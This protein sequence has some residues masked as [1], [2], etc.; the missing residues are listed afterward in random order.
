MGEFYVFMKKDSN[1]ILQFT[2]PHE[3]CNSTIQNLSQKKNKSLYSIW[4]VGMQQL[5]N[6]KYGK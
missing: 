1:S 2:P 3:K 5:V 4:H 6:A